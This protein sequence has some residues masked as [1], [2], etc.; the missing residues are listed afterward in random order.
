VPKT[1][2]ASAVAGSERLLQRG[3]HRIRMADVDAAGIIYFASPLRWQEGLVNDWMAT[4][5]HPLSG[6]LAS[7]FGSP[8]VEA[9]ARYL[10]P[11]H[12]DDELDLR[13]V[14][15]RC[16]QKSFN[17]R[18]D[19]ATPDGDIGTQV[20]TTLVWTLTNSDGFAASADLP[21]WLRGALE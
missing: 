15:E 8:C 7:G 10:R 18:M 1:P 2:W 17:L 6:L 9:A 16:G 13:L 19:A 11:M 20:R 3:H 14:C 12:L 5:G 4:I 21:Q